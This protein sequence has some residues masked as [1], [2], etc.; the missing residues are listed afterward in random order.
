MRRNHKKMKD[1]TQRSKSPFTLLTEIWIVLFANNLLLSSLCCLYHWQ[2]NITHC[3][4]NDDYQHFW[5]MFR[6]SVSIASE[7]IWSLGLNLIFSD[8]VVLL[9]IYIIA[10]LL[11]S[12]FFMPKAI[13]GHIGH[14]QTFAFYFQFR[15]FSFM[16]EGVCPRMYTLMM[17][18]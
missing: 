2:W 1:L 8:L 12:F 3:N 9:F 16:C 11:F 15:L 7:C 4:K 14:C 18:R 5:S 10:T 17:S 6:A 13:I